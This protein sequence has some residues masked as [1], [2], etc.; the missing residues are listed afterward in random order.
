MKVQT[1]QISFASR[2]EIKNSLVYVCKG[3][4]FSP[5]FQIFSQKKCVF[6]HTLTFVYNYSLARTLYKKITTPPHHHHTTSTPPPPHHHTT[7]TPPPHHHTTTTPPPHHHTTTTPPHNHR[8]TTPPPH[9]HTTTTPPP[10]HHT[11]TTPPHHHRTTTYLQRSAHS[12]TQ[13]V[14]AA[15][16]RMLLGT[17]IHFFLQKLIG[18]LYICRF[19]ERRSIK[20]SDNIRE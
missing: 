15:R 9:H 16:R 2:L 12:R 20:N 6:L 13:E 7:T 8:T 5:Y 1:K 17:S 10:H 3:T 11:T 4:C 18:L 19:N 14:S